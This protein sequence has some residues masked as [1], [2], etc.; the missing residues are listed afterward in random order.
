MMIYDV[1]INVQ[2]LDDNRVTS[3]AEARRHLES[4]EFYWLATTR[5]NSQPHMMPVLAVWMDG[6]LFFCTSEESRKGKNLARN[7]YCSIAVGCDIAHLVLEGEA[8]KVRDEETLRRVAEAYA[9]KY[10]W[11]VTIR[12]GAFYASGAPTAGPPP[13]AVHEVL[14][15]KVFGFGL[16]EAFNSTCWEF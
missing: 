12:D 8:L 9:A 10:D 16:G 5:P 3:W 15:V 14:P 4:G 13:Y 2:P 7:A 6:A 11:H 1:P